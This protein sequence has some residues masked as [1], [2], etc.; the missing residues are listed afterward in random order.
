[1][2]IRLR[3]SSDHIRNSYSNIASTLRMSKADDAEEMLAR[4]PS[5]KNFNDET[6]LRSGNPRFSGDMILLSRIRQCQGRLNDA[7]RLSSKALT[8][9]QSMLG[10]RLK[11][12][13]S[14]YL[15]AEMLRQGENI[16]SA[17]SL[18][19]ECISISETLP[20]GKGYLARA[21]YKISLLYTED[22]NEP[23]MQVHQ[24]IARSLKQ[25]ILGEA[26]GEAWHGARVILRQVSPES[27]HIFDLLLELYRTCNG[28]WED[29]ADQVSIPKSSIE[30]FL[31]YAAVFLGN[32]GNYY[33]RGDQKFIPRLPKEDL[34]RICT[35]STKATELYNAVSEPMYAR[36]PS[37]LG[38]PSKVAQ[39]S[40][41]PGDLCLTRQEIDQVSKELEVA[42][43]YPENTRI[44]KV[45][46]NG[47]TIYNVLQA[48]VE[49]ND[50]HSQKISSQDSSISLYLLRGDHSEELSR[51]CSSLEKAKQYAANGLQ[52]D[53][54]EQY[55]LSFRSGDMEIFRES[56]KLWVKDIKPSVETQ[57]GFVEPYRDP[58]G[59]RAEFEGLVAFVDE[60]ETK[61]LTRLVD[62][63][64]K[65]IRLLPWVSSAWKS[66]DKG[67]FEKEPF[68]PPDFTSLQVESQF[69]DIRQDVGFKNFMISNQIAAEYDSTRAAPAF[70][71]PSDVEV[72]MASE[73]EAYY[74]WVVLHELLG[75]GTGKLLT[76]YGPDSFNFDITNPPLSPLTGKPIKSWYK[77]GQSWTGV[78]GDLA[79][80]IDECRAECVGAYLMDNEEL[81][82]LCGFDR[83]KMSA[84]DI[85]YNVYLQLGLGGLRALEN[86]IE[87]DQTW[88]QAHSRAH[89]A[90][91]RTLLSAPDSFLTIH[92]SP[93]SQTLT[94]RIDR[95]KLLT[96]GKPALAALL[97]RLHIY[98]CTADVAACRR[99]FEDLTSVQGVFAEWRRIVLREKR[100]RKVLVQAN[101]VLEADGSVALR[102]YEASKEGMVRSWAERGV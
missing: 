61:M 79:T 45:N 4:C 39:S 85:T 93:L 97:L 95:S 30:E 62:E 83:D 47:K 66:D 80:S 96:H 34:R 91:F 43:I 87:D 14:L 74:I 13:D 23:Q 37:S 53:I 58:Y 9:P 89:F 35:R 22:S 7:I 8:L 2:D 99:Y 19:Q 52:R 26:L 5:L 60:E 72:Y 98:R 31:E 75:H 56:Q 1:M 69:N 25:E 12:C 18:M 48:S 55:L 36:R 49:K 38:F 40:Y 17:I 84:A 6:F 88:G 54:I 28:Q 73:Y 71:D 32:I 57:F 3:T 42:S 10:N 51:V 81:L 94:L 46:A 82:E 67:P 33:G 41:Y 102:E 15:V 76:Q 44:T 11:T 24:E 68:E 63:S 101:T 21:H 70:I 86:Y 77:P 64:A 90:I 20:E 92:H 50:G 78:F 27:T 65:Y 16:A 59:I 29:F 100:T